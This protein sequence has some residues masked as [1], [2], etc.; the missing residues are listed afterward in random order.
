MYSP[1][2]IVHPF[3]VLMMI[4]QRVVVQVDDLFKSWVLLSYKVLSHLV[5]NVPGGIF[6]TFEY[7]IEY[8]PAPVVDAALDDPFCTITMFDPLYSAK[9]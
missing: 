2:G 3:E 8:L 7:H 4:I 9:T 1:G 6:T 5:V